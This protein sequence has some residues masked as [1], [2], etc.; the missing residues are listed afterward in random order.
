MVEL[1]LIWISELLNREKPS[2]TLW[3]TDES[4]GMIRPTS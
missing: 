3:E 4:K 1:I 2:I